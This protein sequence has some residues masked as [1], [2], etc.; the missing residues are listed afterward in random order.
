MAFWV[1]VSCQCCKE[2]M[3]FLGL[4]PPSQQASEAYLKVWVH[5]P[6]A[7]PLVT[8]LFPL[9]LAPSP[10]LLMPPYLPL[11]YFIQV[12]FPQL[13]VVSPSLPSLSLS[14]WRSLGWGLLHHPVPHPRWNWSQAP[15]PSTFPQ[16]LSMFQ[17]SET[18]RVRRSL[19]ACLLTQCSTGYV[20]PPP[21]SCLRW[22]LLSCSFSVTLP[23]PPLFP[24]PSLPCRLP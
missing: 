9:W 5:H 18:H 21:D 24:E 2:F 23:F 22:Q 1:I 17:G 14:D 19:P 10:Q 12:P 15:T 11:A 20:P 16:S 3:V 7:R 4:V 13:W 8:P 6:Q